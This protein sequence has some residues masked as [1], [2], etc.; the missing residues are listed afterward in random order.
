MLNLKGLKK[1]VK[2]LIEIFSGKELNR[3]QK[4][5]AEDLEEATKALKL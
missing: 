2:L 5:L 4:E 3:L 1:D